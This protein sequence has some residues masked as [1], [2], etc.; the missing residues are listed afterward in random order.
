VPL[1]E[2]VRERLAIP[3]RARTLEARADPLTGAP[4]FGPTPGAIVA[5]GPPDIPPVHPGFPQGFV[6]PPYGTEPPPRP[7]TNLAGGRL[8]WDDQYMFG[9]GMPV[10]LPPD[11]RLDEWRRMDLDGERIKHMSASQLLRVLVEA[12]PDVSRGLWDFLRLMNPGWTFTAY[13]TGTHE[14][15][16]DGQQILDGWLR[17]MNKLYGSVNVPVNRAHFAGFLRGALFSEL[18]MDDRG[19][20]AVDLATPD[21]DYARFRQY[22][23]PVR[24][25]VWLLGQY[26]AGLWV[27]LS[28]RETIQYIPIDPAP[29]SPYGRPICAPAIF[30]SLFLLGLLVDLRRVVAQQGYPRYDI[31]ILLDA[32]R[33]SAPPAILQSP[34]EWKKW[35]DR[36]IDDVKTQ[37]DMLEP[38]SAFVHTDAVKINRPT[39]ALSS[40][41]LS[42]I[43]PVIRALER[44]LA[45]GLKTM[46][47]LQGTIEGQSEANANRQWELQAVG[48]EAMQQLSEAD[49]SEKGQLMCEAQGV[50]CDVEWRFVRFR[51]SERYRDAMTSGLEIDNAAKLWMLGVISQ[52]GLSEMTTGEP[53]DQPEPRFIPRTE[54]T[55][56]SAGQGTGSPRADGEPAGGSPGR[57]PSGP[58][59]LTED[60][61]EQDP[62][63]RHGD[64]PFG[65]K[66]PDLSRLRTA[67]RRNGKTPKDTWIPPGQPLAGVPGDVV[68]DD[69]DRRRLVREWDRAVPDLAGILDAEPPTPE[70]EDERQHA[71][72]IARA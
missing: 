35:V 25:R 54:T 53:P 10:V 34:L 36:T 3:R 44:Q 49:L 65:L 30:S 46:P 18:V 11:S 42:D 1:L 60:G 43:D 72:E 50:Q 51:A 7:S 24:G 22:L 40:D 38:D 47:L 58:G 48:I 20:T 39:G 19:R 29:G 28:G 5:D 67:V 69:G 26:Q 52:D 15:D 68:Y 33:K 8:S 13:R 4:G 57:P 14:A 31:E 12:S 41:A 16:L 62:N 45:R 32:L 23:D 37:Y 17:R 6:F 70:D 61:D 21:P 59:S 27:D 63:A 64:R 56:E 9:G 66:W 71:L 55:P 2:Q